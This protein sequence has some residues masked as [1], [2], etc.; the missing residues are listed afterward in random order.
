MPFIHR[1]RDAEIFPREIFR[2]KRHR[3]GFNGGAFKRNV[4]DAELVGQGIRDIKLGHQFKLDEGD[5]HPL[6]GLFLLVNRHLKIGLCDQT[7]AAEKIAKTLFCER[8]LFHH[9]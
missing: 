2:D 9:G 7:G 1:D 8:R 6:A 3:F 5:P 4:L